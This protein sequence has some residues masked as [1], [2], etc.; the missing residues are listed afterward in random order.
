[1]L[2]QRH[3]VILKYLIHLFVSLGEQV[4]RVSKSPA[5]EKKPLHD[6][7]TGPGRGGL[8]GFAPPPLPIVAT[9]RLLDLGR[10][11]PDPCDGTLGCRSRK[12][13][14]LDRARDLPEL[15]RLDAV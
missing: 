9:I 11:L 4:E 5:I 1:M 15:V 8:Q 10:D 6:S 2:S 3:H 12:P 13:E 7:H 14:V